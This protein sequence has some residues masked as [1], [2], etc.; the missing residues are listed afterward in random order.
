MDAL[1]AR[2]WYFRK[3]Y[4]KAINNPVIISLAHRITAGARTNMEKVERIANWVKANIRYQ[5]EPK[6]LDIFVPPER[7]IN[8]KAGDCEDFSV[9]LSSLAGVVGIPSKWKVISQNGKVWSHI[10]P[11]LKVDGSYK[12]VDLTIPLPLFEEFKPYVKY[13]IYNVH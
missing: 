10:Y 7:L 11:L 1:N 3:Y 8:I 13:R 6:K 5:K 4:W 9:L 12:P 2:I